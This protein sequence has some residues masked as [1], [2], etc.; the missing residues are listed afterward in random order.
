MHLSD[1]TSEDKNYFDDRRKRWRKQNDYH[2]FFSPFMQSAGTEMTNFELS[3][4][5]TPFGVGSKYFS[6]VL[7]E[8]I[9]LRALKIL[10][11][12]R[13]LF[14]LFMFILPAHAYI[15]EPNK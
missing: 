6:I 12:L 3:S 10:R 7:R 5:Y 8:S 14:P 9:V 11:S 1:G 15:N 2:R 4:T 13:L